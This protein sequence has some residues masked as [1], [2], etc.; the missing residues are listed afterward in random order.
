MTQPGIPNDYTLS[1]SCYG[2]RLGC[3]EDQAFA[4]VAMG[5]RRIELGL[6]ESPVSLNGFEESH[7]ETGIEVGSL[8]CGCLD[9]RSKTI[10]GTRLG[11][12][13]SDQRERALVSCRR[14][15]RLAASLGGATVIL[16]GCRIENEEL[17]REGDVLHARLQGE[18]PSEKLA[19]EIRSFVARVQKKG[20]RQLEHLCRSIHTL[21]TEFP[22]ARIALEPGMHYNDLLSFEAMGWV[23]DD[24]AGK[25]L[26]YW[27]DTGRLHMREQAGL[28]PQGQWLDAYADRMFGT[29]LHDAA[30]GYCEMPPGAGEVD[31]RL[32]R[33]YLTR[34]VERVIE[35]NPRHG[36]AEILASI[37]LLVDLG[38]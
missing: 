35:V 37:Q 32:V 25:G 9:P 6:S 1:T 34:S 31:F 15:I 38:F 19:G 23:L 7:R 21:L 27:H 33:G 30:D 10:T 8:V 36:R 13:D 20:Q 22:G 2:T 26:G 12:P 16:R 11:S 29:H 18:G 5:F 3:I 17:R 24:L 14:H 28:P 4:A